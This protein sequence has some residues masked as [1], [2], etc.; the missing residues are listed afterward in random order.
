MLRKYKN[1]LLQAVERQNLDPTHFDVKDDGRKLTITFRETNLVYA[2][3]TS[4]ATHSRFA[5]QHSVYTGIPGTYPW[6]PMDFGPRSV[7]EEPTFGFD[8]VLGKFEGW[9]RENVVIYLED[10]V[11]PDWWRQLSGS[12]VL[13]GPSLSSEGDTQPFAEE[14]KQEV[15]QALGTFRVLIVE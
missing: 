15:R 11:T 3:Y 5:I 8:I 2:V 7:N 4:Q 14:E 13:F 9:L 10:Q 6:L 1:T 12:D